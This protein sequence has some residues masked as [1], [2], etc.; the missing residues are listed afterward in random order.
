VVVVVLLVAL[1]HLL[2]IVQRLVAALTPAEQQELA[3]R[4][5]VVI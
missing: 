1:L 3:A 5:V 4:E 2:P